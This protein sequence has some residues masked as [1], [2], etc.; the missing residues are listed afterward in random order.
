MLHT[1]PEAARQVKPCGGSRPAS[2]PSVGATRQAAGRYGRRRSCRSPSCCFSSACRDLIVDGE[3]GQPD[4]D[5][6]QWG[7]FWPEAFDQCGEV[8]KDAVVESRLQRECEFG[9]ARALEREREN[10]DHGAASWSLSPR[11]ASKASNARAKARRVSRC[12]LSGSASLCVL[13][14]TVVNP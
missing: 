5:D 11:P 2:S 6:R 14:K 3:G 7:V 8:G 13:S 4:D 12:A 1:S 9:L 10:P